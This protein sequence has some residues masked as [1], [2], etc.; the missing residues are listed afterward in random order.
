M[1]GENNEHPHGDA[2][3]VLDCASRADEEVM[4]GRG[5]PYPGAPV[6]WFYA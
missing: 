3:T 4:P 1:G 2:I 5:N 6:C